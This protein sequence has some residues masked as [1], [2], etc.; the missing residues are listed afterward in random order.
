M[1]SDAVKRQLDSGIA[2]VCEQCAAAEEPQ[3]E[4]EA[5]QEPEL[6]AAEDAQFC[7]TYTTLRAQEEA[8]AIE[9]ARCRDLPD[10]VDAESAFKRWA[11]LFNARWRHRFK[12]HNSE[13]RGRG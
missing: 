13:A 12:A 2:I 10:R 4:A 1:V 11:H 8:A 7:A 3:S 5:L 6:N 9:L